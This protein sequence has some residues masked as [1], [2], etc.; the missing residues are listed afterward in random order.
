MPRQTTKITIGEWS[1]Y[2]FEGDLNT[3]I[4]RLS[5]LRQDYP[6]QTVTL[7]FECGYYDSHHYEVS[8]YRP[9][10]EEE[11]LIREKMEADRDRSNVERE[12]RLLK[13]LKKKYE[14]A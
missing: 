10:T 9:E 3:I 6:N 11:Q 7:S 12:K 2:E 13:E 5:I 8:Y 1:T 4:E 14:S